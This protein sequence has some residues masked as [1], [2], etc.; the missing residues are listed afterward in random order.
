M[1]ELGLISVFEGYEKMRKEKT[2]A[3]DAADHLKQKPIWKHTLKQLWKKT[4]PD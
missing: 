4:I 2:S 1:P 3:W